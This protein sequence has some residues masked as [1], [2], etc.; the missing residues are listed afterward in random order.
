MTK[1]GRT[2]SD[3]PIPNGKSLA[4]FTFTAPPLLPFKRVF[5]TSLIGTDLINHD[6]TTY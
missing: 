6:S 3:P 4:G 5:A 2:P 1:T